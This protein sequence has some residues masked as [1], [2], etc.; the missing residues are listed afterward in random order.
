MIPLSNTLPKPVKHVIHVGSESFGRLTAPARLLPS[1]LIIGG[2]RCGTTSLYH[3]LTGHPAILKPALH[4]GIH[5]FDTNYHRGPAWYRG[6]FPLRRHAERIMDVYGVQ[7]QTFESSP[8]YLYHPYAASR[9]SRDLPGARVVVLVRNPVERAYSQHAHEVARGFEMETDFNR[10]LALEPS[11]LRGWH[12]RLVADPRASSFSHQHHAYTAHGEYST[13]L[14][15]VA[16]QVGRER[17]LVLDADQFF[18]DPKP[19]YDGVL[20]FLGVPHLGY[21]EFDQHNARPQ[22]V[23]VSDETRAMLTAHFAPWDAALTQWLGRTPS[24]RA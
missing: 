21:P 7:G 23:P 4:Q 17:M 15:Q 19:V 8:Y 24:W 9:I 14:E 6:H 20:D 13:Y 1:F 18:A 11:R 3:S 22:P 2:Q 5:Y 10:A 12:G 16:H